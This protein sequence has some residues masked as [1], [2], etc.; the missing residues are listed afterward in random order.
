MFSTSVERTEE[1]LI[2]RMHFRNAILLLI[3][4]WSY[5]LKNTVFRRVWYWLANCYI[6]NRKSMRHILKCQKPV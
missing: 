2:T 4:E 3:N 6:I 5:R 1:E